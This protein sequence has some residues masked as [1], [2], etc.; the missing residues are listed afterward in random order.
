MKIEDIEKKIFE[1]QVIQGKKG[2]TMF[3]KALIGIVE[4]VA[5][6]RLQPRMML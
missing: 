2:F 4:N 6:Q 3:H 1:F 5:I